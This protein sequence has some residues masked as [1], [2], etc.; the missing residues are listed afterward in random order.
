MSELMR[1]PL[2]GGGHVIVEL[3][4]DTPGVRRASRPG[5]RIEAAVT[6]LQSALQPIREAAEAALDTFRAAGPDEVE[7]ELGVKLNAEAGALIAK[8]SAEGHLTVKLV[9]HRATES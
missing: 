7:I 4:E 6:S 8:S 2:S 3:P 5:E 9:W 1:M